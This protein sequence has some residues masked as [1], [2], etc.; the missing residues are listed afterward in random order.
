M[1]LCE[2]GGP[3]S[4]QKAGRNQG[5]PHLYPEKQ[6][7]GSM[8]AIFP[9]TQMYWNTLFYEEDDLAVSAHPIGL[10]APE[11]HSL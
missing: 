5:H 9:E 11:R 1:F 2:P 7:I 8:K 10:N 6:R 4:L 3:N